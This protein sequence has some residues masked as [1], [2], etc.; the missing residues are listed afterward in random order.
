MTMT[1][2]EDMAMAIEKVEKEDMAMAIVHYAQQQL[3][4]NLSKPS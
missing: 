4:E 3:S 1:M 2:E